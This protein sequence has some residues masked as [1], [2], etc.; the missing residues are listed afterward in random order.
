MT[1]SKNENYVCLN[2]CNVYS[3][4]SPAQLPSFTAHSGNVSVMLRMPLL[5][6]ETPNTTIRTHVM[7]INIPVLN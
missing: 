3:I 2:F 7:F 4:P 5:H 1:G 6:V